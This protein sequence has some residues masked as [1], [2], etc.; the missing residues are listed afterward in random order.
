M[1][2]GI[3]NDTD[4]NSDSCGESSESE[5]EV[6]PSR[7]RQ[8]TQ[9]IDSDNSLGKESLE[10]RNSD[11]RDPRNLQSASR[12][13]F[14]KNKHKWSST[15]RPATTRTLRNNIVH[16]IPGHQEPGGEEAREASEPI[17]YLSLFFTDEMLQQVVTFTNAEIL[18][19]KN[20][21]KCE[22]RTV[23]D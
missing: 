8:R 5:D 11:S 15:P 9:I 14:G 17:Q 3:H 4:G 10:P 6:R 18:I 2:K 12:F 23:S 20:K 16:F 21:Y 1:S 22:T 19:R 7:K 13:L